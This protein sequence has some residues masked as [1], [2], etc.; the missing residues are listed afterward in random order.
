MSGDHGEWAACWEVHGIRADD[1]LSVSVRVGVIDLDGQH[2]VAISVADESPVALTDRLT[3][4][5][6]E[7]LS[8]AK[9][10][11]DM[12]A[13]LR[14]QQHTADL[15]GSL[16]RAI[17]TQRQWDKIH[18]A[19]DGDNPTDHDMT[20]VLNTLRDAAPAD[21]TEPRSNG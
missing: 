14:A 1:G 20:V 2:V 4:E 18:R 11:R 3:D 5:A 21:W 9:E 13:D 19:L 16:N 7:L 15:K 17:L 10:E 12:L 8:W 6:A